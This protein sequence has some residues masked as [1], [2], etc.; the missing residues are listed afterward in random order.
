MRALWQGQ[1][2][3]PAWTDERLL[4]A[5]EAVRSAFG[6]VWIGSCFKRAGHGQ[7]AH[8]AGLALDMGQGMIREE[9]TELRR[10]CLESPL[11][12]YVEP[13]YLTP[14]WVHAEISIAPPCLPGRGY[15]FLSPGD[16]GPHIFLLQDLLCRQG[17]PCLL[18]GHFCEDTRLALVS[19]QSRENLPAH[20]LADG[21]LWNHL[22]I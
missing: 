10:F 18:T 9:R 2:G 15:P 4:Q 1:P 21:A 11:F 17:F 12:S 13:G 7:S 6:P 20:G 5:Y 19:Y 3:Y 22:T 16:A 14:T 8:Y